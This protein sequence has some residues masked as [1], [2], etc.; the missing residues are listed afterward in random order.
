MTFDLTFDNRFTR[1]LPADAEPRNFTRQVHQAGFSRVQP[2]PVSAPKWVAGSKEVADLIGLDPKW[3]G[4][5]ELTEVLAGNALTDGMDPFA[6]CYGGHQFG[7]W[8]GQLGDG[9]AIN[10][11]EVVTADEKH[12]TLQLKGAGLTPYSR[13]ADGLAVLRSSV[14]EFLCS[15]AM[16]HLGVPTTRALSL[17][18]TGEK[19]LRDMFYDG[20]PEH[21]LGAVVCRVAP[22]FIRF[23]NFEIFASRED[24][25]TLQTLVEHT[26]RSEFPHLLSGDGPDT[27]IGPDVI[28]AMFEEVCRTTAEMVVHWMRVG[29]VHG[30]MNTDNMSILGLTIDYGPYGWLEDYDPDWTPNTTDA[31]GRRYRY[32]HQPQ[33]A[34]W[35]LVALANALVP[36]VKEAEPLQRGIAVYVEEFQKS[37]HSMMA[38]KLGLSKYESETD[39]ELVDSLL[40]LLQL[41]ETDMTIFYRRL[42]DIELG[43]R[44]Q[45][46]ALELAVVLNH[47]S[48]AHYVADEVTE[49]YKQALMDWMRSYQSRVL[50]DDGFPADDSQR[51][52]RMN[53]VNP[54][55]VLRNYLAQLA[56]DACDKGDDSMVSELL[57]VLRRPYDDQPGKERFAE[58]RPEWARHRPGCSMLSCSS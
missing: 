28:A 36:L 32:A 54:K 37:W 20:H 18:L 45:P 14:R 23:G 48:E 1:D 8:A 43:T 56:I 22:S 51:R 30:V 9:R 12:W 15:E 24:T 6:M 13:T 55:Y 46:V 40:T 3:L 2:T 29:F 47:L 33:I 35:N 58:K 19:V 44:E 5:S 49:E 57:D 34:Q 31:Q 21:E 4:S 39:D 27:E 38:G 25:E 41:A 53:V 17:V 16:H 42:A 50:A 7:N 52:Q 26:I 10:L 11:G